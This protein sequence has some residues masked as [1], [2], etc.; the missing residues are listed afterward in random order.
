MSIRWITP[1]LGTA[2]ALEVVGNPEF[3]LIDVRDLVDKHGN[4]L[5]NVREKIAQGARSLSDGRTTIICCDYGISRSNAI[6]AGVLAK[7]ENIP[8][9]VAVRKV[10]VATGQAEIKVEP[11]SVVRLALGEQIVRKSV[12]KK[13]ILVT[14]GTGFLGAPITTELS[15]NYSVTAPL[16]AELELLKGTTS[17]D[18]IAEESGADCV[19]H[20][21]S[22]RVYTSNI[23][24]GDTITMLRNVIDVC[25]N[26]GL[27]L[28]YLSSWEIYSGYKSSTLLADEKLLPLPKG[29]YG[30]T[31]YLCEALIEHSRKNRGLKCAVARSS[32][33]YGPGGDKPKFIYTFIDKI[34]RGEPIVTHRYTNSRPAL[35]LLYRDDIVSAISSIVSS[36]YCENF[37][38]GTGHLTST[39]EIAEILMRLVGRQC[40]ITEV[41]IADT[42]ACVSMDSRKA[43]KYLNWGCKV[44]LEA[45]LKHI[46][47]AV[48]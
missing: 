24:L 31:K 30:E 9:S 44:N 1:I 15:K 21:A 46:V 40:P 2:P 43:Q 38:L 5:D 35:D 33:V 27:R 28:V 45:G 25:V 6:A 18:L 41:E 7:H 47:N 11:L 23:A 39:R 14:G 12:G 22:P 42:I 8:L 36:S 19:V 13:N 20:C 3:S 34:S 10:L 4:N 26:R 48:K 32:P 17:L 29:P 37:N 16:R